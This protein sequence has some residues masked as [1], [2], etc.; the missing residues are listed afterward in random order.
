MYFAALPRSLAFDERLEKSRL[1]APVFLMLALAAALPIF[2]VDIPPLADY[3]NHLARM[4]VIAYVDE[5]PL[6]S[7]FYS[8][9]WAIIPNLMMDL[10]V[11]PLHRSMDIYLAGKAFLLATFMVTVT[12]CFA[13]HYA[14]YRHWSPWPLVSFLFLYNNVLLFGLMNYL[15][16]L[17]V[18]LWGCAAWIALRGRSAIVR[19]VVSVAFIAVLF[20]SHLF[21]VGLYGL[22]LMC[23]ELWLWQ[24]QRQHLTL[25]RC[26]IDCLAFGVPFL[27]I[28]PPMLKSPTIGLAGDYVW[29]SSGK[30]DG[31]YYIFQNYS[32]LLDMSLAALMVAALVW[33]IQ[34][35]LL[36]L[37]PIGWYLMGIGTVVYMIMPRMLFSSWVADQRLPIALVFMMIGFARFDTANR[38][39][40][41]AL[42]LFVVLMGITRFASEQLIWQNIDHAYSDFR[43]S[44]EHIEP[45]SKVLVAIAD[46]QSGNEAFNMSLSHAA[47][48]AM[49]ERSS[50]VTTAFSVQGK[51][52]LTVKP[53]YRDRVDTQDG[54]PP[55]ASQLVAATAADRSI[56]QDAYWANWTEQYDYVY[57]LYTDS[58]PNP[59]PEYLTSV[60]EGNRFQ[61]YRIKTGEGE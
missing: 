49:I 9:D 21:A 4:H 32:D 8:I 60:Y 59:A 52:V 54:E 40:R 37:H 42:Y 10:I 30:L 38:T 45:G 2:S 44:V 14:L 51:Q 57:I 33:A 12:G 27:M 15:F 20:V 17:G 46:Q 58:D 47:C 28:I 61:L 34:S 50:L 39:G 19:G 11:P 29:E 22:G 5:N 35:R 26:V 56:P 16:G 43:R 41:Y 24:R 3:I 48:I 53:E 36:R 25:K 1:L 18:A 6:L 13:L 23:C 31:L 55:T 7:Q